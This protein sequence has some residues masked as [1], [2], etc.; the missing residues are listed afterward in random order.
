MKNSITPRRGIAAV[1]GTAALVLAAVAAPAM[2]DTAD[3]SVAGGTLSATTASLSLTSVTLDASN[4]QTATGSSTWTLKDPRGTGAAWT[5]SA[6][7][8]AFTSAAG[9]VETVART[10]AVGQLTITPGGATAEAGSDAN[11]NITVTNRAMTTSNQSLVT[12]SGTNKGTYTLSPSFSL[13]IPANTFRS[14]F[15]TGTSGALNAFTGT[16]TYTFA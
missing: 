14:N 10:I 7:A 15:T 11:T 5:L 6:L 2:A 8:T 4:T 1:V 13:A 3:S 16:I 12:S 9:S